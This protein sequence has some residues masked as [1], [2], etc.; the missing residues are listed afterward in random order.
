ME[1]F[2]NLE[3]FIYFAYLAGLAAL[4]L[5]VF[6]S[7]KILVALAASCLTVY[8][9]YM[10]AGKLSL[11]LAVI[12]YYMVLSLLHLYLIKRT[13]K[14][15]MTFFFVFLALVPL[16]LVR[17]GEVAPLPNPAFIGISYLTFRVVQVLL[18]SSDGLI[19]NIN[20]IKLLTFYIFMPTLSQGP[21]ARS[22]SFDKELMPSTRGQYL[23]DLAEGIEL[24]LIGAVY[25]F[26]FADFTYSKML[27]IPTGDTVQNLALYA[28]AYG[29][30]LFFDFAGYSKMA[31]GAGRFFGIRIIKNFD[32][33]FLATNISDFWNRWH[34]S[35]SGW[36]RDYVFMRLL[37]WMTKHT[38]LR[39]KRTLM[40]V[41]GYIINLVLMGLWHG[42]NIHYLLYGLFHGLWLAFFEIYKKNLPF[43]KRLGKKL[44]YRFFGW[45]VT[46]AGIF[47]GFLIFSG[48]LASVLSRLG[49]FL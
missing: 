41:I 25:K 46:M 13:K 22:R 31:V 5:M 12:S 24:I 8:Y 10:P 23:R 42:L 36:L 14:D 28:L 20:P 2:A 47:F 37:K 35:L 40:A 48:R 9:V 16:L 27:E 18:E 33:P 30:F 34:I 38:S 3:F 26:V 19:V 1:L 43:E 21:I 29:L 39:K 32:A 4:I 17:I 15:K 44:W 49:G 11:F 45:I 6:P 7:A